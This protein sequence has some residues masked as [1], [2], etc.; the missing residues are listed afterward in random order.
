MATTLTL[1]NSDSFIYED[2]V[3]RIQTI[4]H[5]MIEGIKYLDDQLMK[6]K[7]IQN[8][9]K[10]HPLI[11]IDPYGN[12]ITERYIAH[13]LIH[14]VVKKFQK[15]HVPKY[16]QQW[17]RFGEMVEN[18]II[19]L[20]E[21]KLNSNVAQLFYDYPIITYGEISVW[22]GDWENIVSEKVMLRVR[23]NHNSENIQLQLK[24][25]TNSTNMELRICLI[26]ENTTPNEKNWN[27]GEIFKATDTIMSANLYQNNRMILGKITLEKVN[28]RM[29]SLFTIFL[30]L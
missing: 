30:F 13:E 5:Q 28:N 21:S 15:N 20:N 24:K 11:I 25:Q 26:D 14:G 23:L 7:T 27:E 9:L 3:V 19:P 10:S 8:Q 18:E 2:L 17:I 12:P 6:A 22:I 1:N 4:Q 16:L 29:D